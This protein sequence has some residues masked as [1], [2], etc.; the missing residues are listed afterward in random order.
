MMFSP[1]CL[2]EKPPTLSVSA[3]RKKLEARHVASGGTDPPPEPN[4]A[5]PPS[6]GALGRMLGRPGSP[7]SSLQTACPVL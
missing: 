4:G 1:S 6:T 7:C 3:R 5:G 2:D